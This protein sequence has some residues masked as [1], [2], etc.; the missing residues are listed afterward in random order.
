VV[1]TTS[2]S[3]SGSLREALETANSN[4]DPSDVIVFSLEGTAPYLLSP[5]TPL[6]ALNS[7]GVTIDGTSQHGYA[8]KPV[9]QIDG[10]F[11]GSADGIAITSG[12]N[13]IKGLSITGFDA[14]PDSA[15]IRIAGSTASSN[16][17]ELSYVG[18]APDGVTAD[19]NSSGVVL[20]G[21]NNFIWGPHAG[22]GNVI[23]GNAGH[24]LLIISG[25]SNQVWRNIIG[26][27]AFGEASLGNGG[28]GIR[29]ESGSFTNDIGTLDSGGGNVIAAN[30]GAGVH[31]IGSTGNR[32]SGNSIFANAGRGI[33]LDEGGIPNDLGDA[34]TGANGLQN[35]PVLTF[36]ASGGGKLITRGTFSST[37]D[38]SFRLE[39][40]SSPATATSADAEGQIHISTQ[41][42]TTDA[43]GLASFRFVH[44]SSVAVWER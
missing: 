8:G 24:G 31:V 40:F 1:T 13:V 37:P 35:S 25:T 43:S 12:S 14:T 10:D 30:G 18:V 22:E 21:S 39:F 15:G 29:I 44:D 19:G 7:G 41:R 28:D 34:D 26:G 3:G 20:A 11:A 27:T 23:S 38:T 36:T 9:F 16:R 4:G 32:I 5:L 6:P 42:I 33:A 2:D 17:V